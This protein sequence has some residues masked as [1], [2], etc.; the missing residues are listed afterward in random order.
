LC[1]QKGIDA[2]DMGPDEHKISLTD[3]E[4]T[5]NHLREINRLKSERE[6]MRDQLNSMKNRV[7]L[8]WI[9]L[10]KKNLVLAL[11][12]FFTKMLESV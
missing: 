2:V 3:T 12:K 5:S 4:I 6:D 7:S 10:G 1:E 8:I 9:F 11:G